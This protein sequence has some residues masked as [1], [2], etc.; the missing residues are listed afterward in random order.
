LN[1]RHF[2]RIVRQVLI[3][4]I[5]AL[6]IVAGALYWQ[7]STS[8]RTVD[9]IQ[10]SDEAIAQTNLIGRLIIDEES[11]L[12]GYI[13][14]GDDRF[15]DP[16]NKAVAAFPGSLTYLGERKLDD[17]EKKKVAQL[18]ADHDIWRDSF[19]TPLIA[20][21]RARGGDQPA[22]RD[23]VLN[24]HGKQLMDTVRADLGVVVEAAE[25]HRARR[26][27]RWRLQVRN[28][29]IGLLALA[30]AIGVFIGLFTRNRLHVV[31]AAY[32]TSLDT[33]RIKNEELFLSEQQ[34]RTTL[35]SIGDGVITCDASGD[36][37]M[38]NQ[39]AA[40]ITGW[41]IEEALGRP[42][43]SV[44]HILHATTRAAVESPFSKVK[45]LNAA[46]GLE[47]ETVLVR[48]DGTEV[49][50]ADSGAPIRDQDGSITGVI[51]VFRD[52]T[53]EK[54]TQQ[55]LISNEKLAVAG[56]LAA[57]IAHE[58]HNPLDAVANMLYLMSSGSTPEETAQFV[59]MAQQ[60]I[61]RVT[62]ISRSMLSLYRESTAPV[63]VNIKGILEGTL[64][65]LDHL[66]VEHKTAITVSFS[67][68][69]TV[70]GFP[71]ELRQVFTNLVV[72][73]IEAAGD[74]GRIVVEATHLPAGTA[75][76]GERH[77][78]GVLVE[79][80]DSGPGVAENAS[81]SLFTPF[82]STKGEQGTG[83]GLWVSRGI[84]RKH[85]GSISLLSR[86]DTHGAIARVFLATVPVISP[87]AD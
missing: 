87:G 72:N 47:S 74:E 42:L 63:P 2:N 52:V 66:I 10:D 27:A 58:I 76:T 55:A 73:A 86:P 79:V 44:F 34:L 32:Q 69:L 75:G 85:G 82:F 67:G 50:I 64:V 17:D 71:A 16:Y 20:E 9:R 5:L 22:T 25:L 53:L 38:M 80:V 68:E 28:M 23:V 57:S 78:E 12:R 29:V 59:A 11:A 46:A 19:A 7:V 41:A 37:R 3:F 33:L 51:L 8:S 40:E 45:R 65:L 35:A 49:D 13:A 84:I 48:K 70:S 56:R 31:S 83:L 24:L 18:V 15:L 62:Q 4:P 61:S 54:R 30:V 1:L 39:I 77:E 60:E 21:T 43:E 26:V 6:V 14:T 81:S 36:V